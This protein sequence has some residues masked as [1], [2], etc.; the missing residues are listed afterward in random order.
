[1]GNSFGILL[2]LYGCRQFV[3]YAG[4]VLNYFALWFSPNNRGRRNDMLS[5]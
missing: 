5:F 2:K 1:L 3:V 4:L